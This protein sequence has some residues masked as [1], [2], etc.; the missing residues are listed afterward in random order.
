L[1]VP[2]D[3]TV[4]DGARPIL[5]AL[6]PLEGSQEST[7]AVAASLRDL[8]A[9]GVELVGVHVFDATTVPRFWDRPGHTEQTWGAEFL[10]RWCTEPGVHLHLRRGS[11]P[12]TIVDIA[13]REQV[14]L[15]ALGWAQDLGPGHA[16][17]VRAVLT[18]APTPVLLVPVHPT[19]DRTE[20]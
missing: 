15:I 2:P 14:D 11:P 10:S 13:G 17:V 5:R 4:A 16:E 7:D 3:V 8:A 6:I 19:R 12:T 18:H 20:Q 1:V 9:A